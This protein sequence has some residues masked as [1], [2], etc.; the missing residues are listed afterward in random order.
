MEKLNSNFFIKKAFQEKVCL[1]TDVGF[2]VY[3]DLIDKHPIESISIVNSTYSIVDEKKYSK[4]ACFEIK[5]G[6]G[7]VHVFHCLGG[8]V[9]IKNWFDEFNKMKIQFKEM[10]ESIKKEE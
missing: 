7:N 8:S 3:D 10:N 4:S 5:E 9:E 2:M 1:L 6:S